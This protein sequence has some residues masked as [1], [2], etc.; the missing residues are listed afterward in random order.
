[1]DVL[2]IPALFLALV[3]DNGMAKQ[4]V[5]EAYGKQSGIER[6]MDDWQR[7]QLSESFRLDAGDAMFLIKII[8]ERRIAVGWGFP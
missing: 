8:A 7:R 5:L 4:A 2:L 1:M 3:A 6:M